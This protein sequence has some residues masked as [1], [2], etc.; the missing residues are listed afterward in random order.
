MKEFKLGKTGEAD[1]PTSQYKELIITRT[2]KN[3][4]F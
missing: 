1:S 3:G 2:V 4:V